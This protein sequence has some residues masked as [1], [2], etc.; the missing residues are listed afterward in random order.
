M[1]I[2]IA[3]IGGL[4]FLYMNIKCMVKVNIT[5]TYLRLYF[6]IILFRKKH[7]FSRKIDY[8]DRQKILN[9]YKNPE[10]SQKYKKRLDY[11]KYV[12]KAFIFFYVKNIFFYPECIS[13]K[14]SLAIEFVVVNRMLKK[15]L[16]NG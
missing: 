4:L 7:E 14:S 1:G 12:K 15:S 2:L 10:I 8:F 5:F 16:L 3:I 9:R 11:F 13:D 6:Y